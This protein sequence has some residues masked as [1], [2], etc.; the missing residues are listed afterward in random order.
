[1]DSKPGNRKHQS[2]R[3]KD[4]G[5]MYLMLQDFVPESALGYIVSWFSEYRVHLRISKSR[6]T[7][8]GDYRAPVNGLPPR[9]SVNQNLNRYDFLI[10]LVHEMAHHVVFDDY[11]K[12]N[13]F[14]LF[15]RKKYRPKP[16]GSEW[17]NSY[18]HLM[19]PLMNSEVFP[20]EILGNLE[21]YFNNPKAS[22]GASHHLAA[23]LSQFDAPD[24]KDFIEDLPPD[25][26]FQIPGGRTFQKKEKLRKRYRCISLNNKRVYL[27]SP[28]ARVSR[29]G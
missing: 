25:C 15:G 5:M 6:T 14:I 17:K 1:M 26:I 13:G 11:Q 21:K 16:H 23:V 2:R 8:Y 28:V 18:R 19:V 22:T 9:I 7:K 4:R 3:E 27:F 12:K 24:G 29:I 20:G 10:T